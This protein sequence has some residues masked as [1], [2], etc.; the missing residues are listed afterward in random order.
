MRRT[1]QRDIHLQC[2]RGQPGDSYL[3]NLGDGSPPSNQA[4]PTHEYAYSSFGTA[5][6]LTVTDAAGTMAIH[7]E[8]LYVHI[9][10]CTTRYIPPPN[11][12]ASLS[13]AV[14]VALAIVTVGVIAASAAV[15]LFVRRK[16]Q[17]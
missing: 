10:N 1:N 3:W 8:T 6:T 17:S 15:L 7:S 2:N 5:V 14:L 12:N 13:S 4:D 16:N 9:G 11:E